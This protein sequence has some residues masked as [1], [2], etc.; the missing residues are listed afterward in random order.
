M[1]HISGMQPVTPLFR[2]TVVLFNAMALVRGFTSLVHLA[3]IPARGFTST[4]LVDGLFN[5]AVAALVAL[6]G[7]MLRR[8]RVQVIPAFVGVS[9]L[10]LVYAVS[11]GRGINFGVVALAAFYL[12]CLWVLRRRGEIT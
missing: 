1:N 2:M 6:C 10:T 12:L 7:G 3:G 11:M 4:L 5:L 9:V 8:R